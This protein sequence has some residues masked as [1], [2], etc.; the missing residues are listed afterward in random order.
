MEYNKLGKSGLSISR[1]SY[2]SWVTFSNQ[3]NTRLACKLLKC[4][5]DA[6][7]NF[8][9]NAETYA[10]GQSEMIMG[11]ALHKLKLPRDEF[12]VSSKVFWGGQAPLFGGRAK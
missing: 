1:V 12:I 5:F 7:I 6:G 10:D 9:D 4:A 11:K 2:G 3:V 8:F